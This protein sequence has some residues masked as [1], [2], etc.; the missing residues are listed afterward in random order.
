MEDGMPSFWQWLKAETMDAL[1]DVA[2]AS[3]AGAVV[4][5]IT[6]MLRSVL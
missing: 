4:W 2:M 3:G 1:P 6:G 5:I